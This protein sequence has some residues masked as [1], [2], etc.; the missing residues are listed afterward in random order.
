MALQ[1][2]ALLDVGDVF[3]YLK[4]TTPASTDPNYILIESLINRASDFAESYTNGPIINKTVTVKLDGSGSDEIMLP[5]YPVQSI[6]TATMDG[7]DITANV[8]FYPEGSVFLKDGSAFTVGR[9]N[10]SITYVAGYGANTSTI[11]QDIR[12]AVLLICHYWYKRDSLDYSQTY[13]ESEVIV[14]QWRFPSTAVQMLDRYRRPN[15]AVI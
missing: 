12:Q 8:D 5:Y 11:P 7:V 1:S 4:M 6:T 3:A 14:G 15:M 10:V 9:K 13:G 2:N